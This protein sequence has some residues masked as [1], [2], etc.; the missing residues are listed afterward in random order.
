VDTYLPFVNRTEV[1]IQFEN[2]T[3]LKGS[4]F[5]KQATL[6]QGAPSRSGAVSLHSLK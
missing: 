4:F 5:P 3:E 6:T 2:G 1:L